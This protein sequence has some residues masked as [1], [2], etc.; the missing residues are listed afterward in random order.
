MP[1]AKP[2]QMERIGVIMRGDPGN[3][4]EVLGVLN[5][6]TARTPDGRL[7]L[8]PRIVAAGNYSRI[9]IAEVLFEAGNPIGVQRRG[10][11]LEPTESY[12]QNARTAG[13]EDPRITFVEPLRRYVMTYTAYG[14]LGPRVALAISDD[15]I[16]WERLGPARFAFDP[17]LR[18][19][20]DL[21]DNKDAALFPTPV[22][23]PH[24]QPALALIHRPAHVQGGCTVL[25]T[26]VTEQRASIW[27]SYCPLEQAMNN[28]AALSHWRDHTLVAISEQ[29][30][31][32][33]KIGGGTPPIATPHGWLMIYHGVAGEILEGVDHQ[34]KVRYSAGALILDTNDPRKVVYRSPEPL[35]EPEAAEERDGVVPNVVFPTGIDPREHGRVDIYYGMADAVIGVA[36]LTIPEQLL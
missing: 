18:V 17:A 10:Y 26:G 14:P 16:R 36:R 27:I 31:E 3:P 25:P 32:E 2:F 15:L 33:L 7:L 29:P 6:A 23:D 35:L 19:D 9:G 13:C 8:F 5:P 34:M 24:G 20:F 30:W 22:T 4:D 1:T 28:P 21:Y 11:A 12:E